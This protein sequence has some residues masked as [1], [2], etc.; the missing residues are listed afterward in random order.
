MLA[1]FGAAL[2]VAGC[3]SIP[4]AGPVQSYPVTQAADGQNG[5]NLQV[6]A[7]PPGNDWLPQDIVRGFLV[8]AAAFG[9]QE[10]VAKEY[11]TPQAS[12]SWKQSWSAV[13]YRT[14]PTEQA[15]VYQS[16]RSQ[17]GNGKNGKKARRQEPDLATVTIGGT[18]Q[19]NLS[20]NGSYAVPSD[21]DPA[22]PTSGA[23]TFE[24]VKNPDGQWRIA[25]APSVL[26]LTE[27][28][29]TDDY[30]LRNLYFFD[31]NDRYLVPDPVYV[32]L[33]ATPASLMNGLVTDLIT[34]PRD[35]L[36]GGATETAF[37]AGTR[38][39]DVSLVGSTAAVDLV[40]AIAKAPSG[41]LPQVS[42]Q[43]L[44]TLA[45]SG[46]GGSQV[47]SVE[48]L[49]NGKPWYPG[50]SQGN[51]VQHQSGYE[52]PTGASRVFY[53]LDSA[54]YLDSREGVTGKP[55][56]VAKIGAGYSQ[57]AVSPD[58]RY[59]AALR[60]GALFIGP[61]G[62]VLVRRAGSGYTTMSWDPSDNLWATTGGQILMFRGDATVGQGQAKPVGVTV[63][64]YD[65]AVPDGVPFTALRVAPDGVR[66]A[67][68]VGSNE[69]IFGAILWQQ[70][71]GP[72][73]GS[74]KIK[75]E[76]SPLV[77][78]NFA[79][80]AAFT[81]VTWYGPDDV[82]TLGEPGSTGST[83]TE[84]PVNGGTATSQPLDQPIESITASSG[85][86]L[87]AG[88]AKGEMI[89]G[90]TLTGAWTGIGK[91]ISPAYPG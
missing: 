56:R 79:V 26:L 61:V 91:G 54:G 55:V 71:A 29:F 11:L 86:A 74:L 15:P 17:V 53:Y 48:L 32:P 20:G 77:V 66:V 14:G 58:G 80:P 2:A 68:V 3:V 90:P 76:L 82:I 50:N 7:S 73:Q 35:W 78:S 43:L 37:P 33:K 88:G 13:V 85:Y 83:L 59:L 36:A 5:Q 27:D 81:A 4:N 57:V 23:Q 31:P 45:G 8:A 16:T 12:K 69:L 44:W 28:Q 25:S 52:P 30:E 9:D 38:I 1:A 65:G 41:V 87:I 39:G 70:G 47:Q 60:N 42:A 63:V 72:G 18:I 21:S 34:P 51:P 40:G 62:G 46:Q 67:I 6:I 19:A 22:G 10:R 75:I 49:V 64:P 24:L 89:E 84:Y